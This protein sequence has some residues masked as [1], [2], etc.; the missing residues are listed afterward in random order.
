MP[1]TPTLDGALVHD[2]RT[3]LGAALRGDEA[4]TR[5]YARAW[6]RLVREVAAEREPPGATL[7]VLDH[8]AL[9]APFSPEGPVAALVSA[10][11]SIMGGMTSRTFRDV[12]SDLPDALDYHRFSRVV[13]LELSGAGT[14]L[15]RLMAAWQL[16]ITDVGRL[17]GV[18]RQAVQQWLDDGVPAAR[19]PKLAV[20]LRI[21]DLL[22]RNLLPDRVPGVVRTSARAYGN[23]TILQAIGDDDHD[24]VLEVV[25]RSFD[26]SATG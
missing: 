10:A 1:A 17:F 6:R 19:Q 14:G 11:T 26:W 2:L 25:A 22:E 16:S 21:A 5:R 8:L 4:A 24:R 20:V 7:D 15:E 9:T 18:A 23:R 12:P 3:S 13:L